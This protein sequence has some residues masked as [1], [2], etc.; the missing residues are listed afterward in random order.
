MAFV[1]ASG[2]SS[3]S[4]S[5]LTRSLVL[6]MTVA[7]VPAGEFRGPNGGTITVRVRQ[8]R[9]AR[10]QTTPGASI[11][12]DDFNEV[13]VDV[14][15]THLYDAGRL[16]DEELTLQ[17]QDFAAQVTTPQVESIAVGAEDQLASAMNG[18]TSDGSVGT[19]TGDTFADIDKA[20]LTARETLTNNNVPASD[21]FLAVAPDAMTS[22]L[23][24]DKFV[25][26]DA[27]GDDT[28]AIRTATQGRIYGMTVIETP[29]LTGGT[30]VAY[31]RSGFAFATA[32]PAQPRGAN[33]SSV[34]T[35]SGVSMRQIFQ[36]QPDILSD[37]SVLSTFAGASVVEGGQRV[38][39]F[40]GATG[41]GDT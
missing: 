41:V 12:Y 28:S 30:G 20:L 1:T 14:S 10:T 24:M 39:K 23:L 21:R 34:T 29:A 19:A 11:T 3:L 4:V 5:L 2:I 25:R 17:L 31:H 15:L 33:D 8:P 38:F 16:T 7:R 6:P 22:I 27:T 37:A 9:A 26:A 40:D 13:G 32:T 36:Y 18:V 35:R